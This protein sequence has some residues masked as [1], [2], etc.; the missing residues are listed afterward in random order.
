MPTLDG[1]AKTLYV[2]AYGED[3]YKEF[4]DDDADQKFHGGL[5]TCE[6]QEHFLHL[7]RHD[8]ESAFWTLFSSLL[9]AYPSAGDS[10]K[11]TDKG[12]QAALEALELHIIDKS[13]YDYRVNLLNLTALQFREALHPEL[14]TLA[15]M[16]VSMC[17][18]IRPEYSYLSPA[19]PKE[20]LHEAMRRILLRQIVSMRGNAIPLNHKKVRVPVVNGRPL[21][22]PRA[23]R[24]TKRSLT[25][26]DFSAD[27]E[28]VV[29]D[30]VD[31]FD[32]PMRKIKKSKSKGA[33]PLPFSLLSLKCH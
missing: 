26:P 7:P 5:K 25:S 33:L 8:V 31:I 15:P 16:L 30:H 21:Q 10:E 14:A 20:H 23:F 22:S 24:G 13:R 1:E 28:P 29:G 9:R 11:T 27:P 12:F 3:A 17:D 6:A 18:Q 19:P 2:A 4:T 32:E